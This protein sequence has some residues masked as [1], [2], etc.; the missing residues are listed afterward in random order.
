MY[1]VV[2]KWPQVL[3]NEGT[4]S[5]R[6]STTHLTI[7]KVKKNCDASYNSSGRAYLGQVRPFFCR[8]SF[9]A[10][11]FIE[12]IIVNVWYQRYG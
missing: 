11:L 3:R 8:H 7:I 4:T 12:K 5:H 1:H 6:K 9:G 10:F 2:E